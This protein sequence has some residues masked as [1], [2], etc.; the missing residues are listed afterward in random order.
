MGTFFKSEKDKAAKGDEWGMPFISC[1]QDTQE[2]HGF[3]DRVHGIS[4]QYSDKT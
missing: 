1:A 2:S 4:C 3:H